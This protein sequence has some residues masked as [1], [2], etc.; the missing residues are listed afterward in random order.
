MAMKILK[1]RLFALQ[2]KKKQEEKEA[3]IA[4]LSENTFGNQI[5]SYVLHPYK[6]KRRES[7]FIE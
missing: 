4:S 2:Q 7:K 3:F 6:V 1:S 5:R